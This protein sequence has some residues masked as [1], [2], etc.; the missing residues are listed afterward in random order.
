LEAP[1]PNFTKLPAGTEFEVV[2]YTYD[3]NY[4]VIVDDR[5]LIV[6]KEEANIVDALR[7]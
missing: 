5:V 1:G 3:G 2:S 6:L 7:R 4:K